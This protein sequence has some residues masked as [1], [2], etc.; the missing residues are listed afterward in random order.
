M[1]EVT[2]CRLHRVNVAL[3]TSPSRQRV[4][5]LT[6]ANVSVRFLYECFDAGAKSRLHNLGAKT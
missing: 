4:L 3:H 2:E 6:F 1:V 5:G